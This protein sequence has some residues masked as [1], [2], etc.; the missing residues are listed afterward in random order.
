MKRLRSRE[1]RFVEETET[2]DGR[3][4][5]MSIEAAAPVGALGVVSRGAAKD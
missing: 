4:K 1:R 3:R 2:S 5:T